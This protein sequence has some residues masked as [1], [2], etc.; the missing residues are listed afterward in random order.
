MPTEKNTLVYKGHPLRR[1]DNLIY[2]GSMAD[3]YIIL[4]QVMESKPTKDISTATRVSVQ[5]Q[6]TDT[7]V[8][9]R[10]LVVRRSD[11][12]SL[13]AAVDIAS[14]WLERALSGR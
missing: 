12:D 8:K 11:K 4:L 1:L 10:D 6:R 9:S 3:P 2:Y 7:K 13:F 5:L 14:I